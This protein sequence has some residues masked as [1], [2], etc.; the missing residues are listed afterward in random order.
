AWA[1]HEAALE[2]LRRSL[3]AL[4]GAGVEPIVVKGMV[5]AYELYDDVAQRPLADV[6][7]RVRPSRFLRAVRALRARGWPVDPTSKQLGSIGFKVGTAL[8]E[9][10][11]T[12]GPPGLCGLTIAQMEARARRR[13]LPSG[14]AVREPDIVDHAI[15]LV[16]NAFKDKLADCPSWSIGDLV[17][18]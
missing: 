5:L 14:I 17:A 4:R 2:G 1:A 10:E 7:L 11:S 15:V 8:V 6:D 3:A 12:V 18:I 16:V 9:I 13:V